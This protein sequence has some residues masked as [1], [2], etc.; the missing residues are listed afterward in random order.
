MTMLVHLALH[1]K[2]I[3][4]ESGCEGKCKNG[5][6][7]VTSRDNCPSSR[8]SGRR[9]PPRLAVYK[10]FMKNVV[11]LA[12]LSV[13]VSACAQVHGGG[14]NGPTADLTLVETSFSSPAIL[15]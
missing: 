13:A 1:F 9:G 14:P 11:L 4:Y 10:K 3:D 7:I 12:L 6:D 15:A 2:S 8:R 5:K